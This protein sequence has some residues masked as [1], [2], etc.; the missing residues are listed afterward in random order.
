MPIIDQGGIL[1]LKMMIH[2]LFFMS[3]ALIQALNNS[4]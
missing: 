1:R 2:E 3:E 4:L